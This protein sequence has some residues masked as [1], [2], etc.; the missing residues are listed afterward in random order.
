M[1]IAVRQADLNIDRQILLDI[2]NQNLPQLQHARRCD[3][4]YRENPYGTAW[5]WLAFNKE[6]DVAVG[7]A[8]VFPR[9]MH[10]CGKAVLGGQV[11]DFAISVGFRSLGPALLL[12]KATL[13]PVWQGEMALCYDTP[14]NDRGMAPFKRMGISAFGRMLRFAKPLKID[15][16][17]SAF[18]NRRILVQGL[19][20]VGNRIL[21]LR[22]SR[23][24]SRSYEVSIHTGCFGGEFSRLNDSM[25][26]QYRIY[27]QRTAAYLNW[28]YR[29]DPLH[30]YEVMTARYHGELLAYAI[31]AVDGEDAYL[32]DI[33]GQE[34][35]ME[36]LLDGVIEVLRGRPVM[37][38]HITILEHSPLVHTLKEVGFHF[39][40]Y[41]RLV[42]AC[43]SPSDVVHPLVTNESNWFL[44][45]ADA[46]I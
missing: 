23:R 5:A 14:P 25:G 17:V 16:K 46:V 39:R 18:V 20:A 42:V 27:G 13:T 45:Y 30:H 15:R 31:F 32:M 8:S 26:D 33:F 10:V 12:Q 11:G 34:T 37:T 22:D 3:W 36:D 29:D 2:L 24:P 43:A 41:S 28:R 40:E 6:T 4:L 7:V 9:L 19:S 21:R 1:S 44:T 38:L 35:A